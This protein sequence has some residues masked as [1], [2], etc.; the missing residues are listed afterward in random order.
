MAG[1][2]MRNGRRGSLL[3]ERV[4]QR[5]DT[6][7]DPLGTVRVTV[8]SPEKRDA[9]WEHPGQQGGCALWQQGGNC[10]LWDRSRPAA[11]AAWHCLS[12][13]R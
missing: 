6:V 13:R 11:V 7:S 10:K 9:V 3:H 1:P 12:A 2:P 5:R 8:P 4:A